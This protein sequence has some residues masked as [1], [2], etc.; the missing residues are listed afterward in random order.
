MRIFISYRRADLGGHAELLV[1]RLADRLSLHFGKSN[2]FLDIITIPPGREFDEFIQEQVAQADAVLAIIGPDW[3]DELQNRLSHNDDFV[4]L[5]VKAALDRHIPLIPVLVGDAPMP[6]VP[7]T[8]SRLTKKNAFVLDSGRDFHD[9]A[10]NLIENLESLTIPTFIKEGA[11]RA[12]REDHDGGNTL[13]FR[14]QSDGELMSYG[15]VIDRWI[16]D[17]KFCDFYCSLLAD[18]GLASYVWETPA[19]TSH[20]LHRIFEF[21]LLS[22]PVWSASPDHHTYAKYFDKNVGDNG[23]IVF[24]NLGKDAL[25]VVPSPPN[26]GIDYSNLAAFFANAQDEQRRALWRTVGRSAKESLTEEPMW[27]S[28]AGGGIAWLHVRLDSLPK[29]YR[30]SPYRIRP[31]I[32]DE[33]D[34]DL[35]A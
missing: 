22:I 32:E 15:Q 11:L 23:V 10:T 18:S 34:V 29:Y 16:T 9:H 4:Y 1:G 5:E 27:I 33:Q 35:N 13:R 30:Y 3:Q 2:V 24:G 20:Y 7:P 26:V 6:S 25:L 14:I 31:S 28:V 12:I 17:P 19:I 21:V 8:L